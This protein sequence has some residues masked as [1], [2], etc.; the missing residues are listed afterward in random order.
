MAKKIALIVLFIACLI[1]FF[2]TIIV[3]S[4][5]VKLTE[6]K[7]LIETHT[8][9]SKQ[10]THVPHIEADDLA[11]MDES[12]YILFDVRQQDE[13]AVSHLKNAILVDPS[14]SV[15]EFR[16]QFKEILVD[17]ILIFYCSV[18]VRSSRLAEQLIVY[19]S[20]IKQSSIYNL[21][22][23]IFGWHNESR[24]LFQQSELTDYIHPYNRV[25]GLA[26]NRSNLKRYNTDIS[27]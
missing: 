23:G 5:T 9:I 26:V 27:K 20:E 3:S 21:K 15:S 4:N 13:Y 16:E 25:W 24:P 6:N 11:N 7:G 22:N 10:Y 12:S 18:G 19:E 1:V 2:L 17:K 14:L 8:F